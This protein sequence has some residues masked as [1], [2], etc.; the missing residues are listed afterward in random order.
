[1]KNLP[2]FPSC[3]HCGTVLELYQGLRYCP[4]CYRVTAAAPPREPVYTDHRGRRYKAGDVVPYGS[5]A[6]GDVFAVY[7]E[8][9][10]RVRGQHEPRHVW[11]L[12]AEGDLAGLAVVLLEPL[13]EGLVDLAYELPF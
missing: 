10:V 5:L 8:Q 1:M 11:K 13:D 12:L 7:G 3:N 2:P 9:C 4:D 6:L